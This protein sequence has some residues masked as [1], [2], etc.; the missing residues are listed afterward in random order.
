MEYNTSK[1][2]IITKE[3]G[4]NIQQMVEYLLTIQDRDLRNQQ[5]KAIVNAMANLSNDSKK[6]ADFWQKIWDELFVISDYKLDIDSP[7]P[8]PAKK[9]IESKPNRINYPDHRIKFPAYG[10]NIEQSILQ[11]SEEQDSLSKEETTKAIAVYLKSLYL[12]YNRDSVNDELIREHLRILSNGKLEVDKNFVLPST[13]SLL[14]QRDNGESDLMQ[15]K[16]KL[17]AQAKA[18]NPAPKKKKKKKKNNSFK[19]QNS[20]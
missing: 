15:N 16:K 5:A 2:K 6:T 4:R 19:S 1:N 3:Y 20:I 17:K 11:L 12:N 9:N 14:H 7:F 13:K 10:K 18:N 8:I